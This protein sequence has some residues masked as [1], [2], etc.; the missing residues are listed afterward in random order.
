MVERIKEIVLKEGFTAG[1]FA[2]EI[3]VQRSSLSHILNGR[4]NPSLDFII[5]TLQRFPRIN[6]DWLLTG[7]GEMYTSTDRDVTKN[8]KRITTPSLFS[9]VSIDT[10]DDRKQPEP[11]NHTEVVVNEVKEPKKN[12]KY[13]SQVL[14]FYS[15][16][17]YQI[18]KPEN[19]G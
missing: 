16:S 17:T 11:E 15:D 6:S 10:T 1:T 5:K 14:I 4:N 7:K 2:D 18:Y 8:E 9:N 3:G 19:P 13:V 12:E